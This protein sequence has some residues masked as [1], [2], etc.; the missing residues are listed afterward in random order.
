MEGKLWGLGAGFLK[1]PRMANARMPQFFR[2]GMVTGELAQ[3]AVIVFRITVPLL[4]FSRSSFVWIGTFL[5][6]AFELLTSVGFGDGRNL[7]K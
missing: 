2:R 1:S 7:C 6:L 4:M 3:G 5:S